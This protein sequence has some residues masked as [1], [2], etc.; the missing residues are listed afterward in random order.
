VLVGKTARREVTDLVDWALPIQRRH[1]ETVRSASVELAAS[2]DPEE[3]AENA[4]LDHD[5]LVCECGAK[6]PVR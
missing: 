3:R 2:E 5:D 6:T 1:L 4:G